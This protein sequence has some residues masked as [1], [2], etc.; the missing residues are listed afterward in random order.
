MYHEFNFPDILAT[1][2][3]AA[4]Q[5]EDVLPYDAKLDFDRLFLPDTLAGPATS[6]S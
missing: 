2:A 5:I 1:S 3:R 4:W 6:V